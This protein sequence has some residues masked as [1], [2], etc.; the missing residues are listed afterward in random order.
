IVYFALV[1]MTRDPEAQKLVMQNGL[2]QTSVH[3]IVGRSRS[4]GYY[5]ALTTPFVIGIVLVLWKEM[6][7]RIVAS[8]AVIVPICI[9]F[10]LGMPRLGL[11]AITGLAYVSVSWVLLKLWR[12]RTGVSLAIALWAVIPLAMSFY[13][14]MAAKYLV[15]S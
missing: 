7:W 10:A 8:V 9:G 6:T 3:S 15:P 12:N 1:L 11:E 13:L 5:L 14:H 2:I 4:F